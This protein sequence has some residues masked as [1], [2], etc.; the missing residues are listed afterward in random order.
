MAVQTF[1]T[2][3]IRQIVDELN[4]PNVKQYFV[5]DGDGDVTDVYHAQANA[6]SGDA[7]LRERFVYNVDKNVVKKHWTNGIWGGASWDI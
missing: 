3:D 1:T 7:C 5:Y 2:S 4:S 6:A